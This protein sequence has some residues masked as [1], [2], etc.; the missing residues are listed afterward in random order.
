V[1]WLPKDWGGGHYPPGMMQTNVIRRLLMY[2]IDE[3]G[4][5]QAL[6]IPTGKV[7]G[8]WNDRKGGVS[9]WKLSEV[10]VGQED[11]KIPHHK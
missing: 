7:Y 8:L 1:G 11:M 4:V 2:G 5:Q 6:D 10:P 9:D 3:A